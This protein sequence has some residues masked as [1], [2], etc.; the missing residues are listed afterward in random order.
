M[1]GAIVSTVIS[2][3]M[4]AN[5]V[6]YERLV[7]KLNQLSLT[8]S[9]CD[10]QSNSELNEKIK[11][12]EL[13]ALSMKECIRRLKSCAIDLNEEFTQ[14][15]EIL[16][17]VWPLLHTF[18]SLVK[19]DQLLTHLATIAT[20]DK[21]LETHV[22]NSKNSKDF[23]TKVVAISEWFTELVNEYKDFHEIHGNEIMRD[24]LW[25]I[26]VHWKPIIINALK[27]KLSLTFEGIDWP[28]I[29]AHNITDHKSHSNA[30]TITSFVLYFNALI[31][32]DMQCKRL[33]QT[34]DS[35]L[36]LPIEV[37]ITPLKKRFQYHFME[38]KS[39]LNRLEKVFQVLIHSLISISFKHL[40]HMFSPN[41][42]YRKL[43]YGFDKTRHSYHKQLIHC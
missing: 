19:L 13:K 32:I 37:M 35:D 26:I 33:S 30:E 18:E 8:L 4:S 20:I 17:N 22:V 25:H 42:I 15:E 7:S 21:N 12:Y 2:M 14:I 16:H 43:W 41:G 24:Y 34:P 23:E 6:K 11:S 1:S 40:L 27:H 36:L 29:S 28:T 39:K 3:Q 5:S 10:N 9:L 38:T 31:T